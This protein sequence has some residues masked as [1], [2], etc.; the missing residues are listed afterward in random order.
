M[1]AWSRRALIGRSLLGAAVVGGAASLLPPVRNAICGSPEDNFAAALKVAVGAR[2]VACNPQLTPERVFAQLGTLDD[3]DAVFVERRTRDFVE[4]R[5]RNVDGWQLAE[6][7]VL[8]F[9]AA[10]YRSA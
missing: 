4:G 5:I 10:Y 1:M 9:A 8:S 6:T 2:C 7:E 3:R